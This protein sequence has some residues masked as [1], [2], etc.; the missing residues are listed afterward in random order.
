M[1]APSKSAYGPRHRRLRWPTP[2]TWS[3]SLPAWNRAATIASCA[4]SRW[5][6]RYAEDDP[7]TLKRLGLIVDVETTGLDPD[8]DRIIELACL[9]FHFSSEGVLYDVLPGY[10]GFEDPGQP[11]HEEVVRLTGIT[12][13]QLRGQKLD[14]QLVTTLA[15]PA[16]L[17]IAHNAGFD[18]CFLERRFPLFVDK[19]WACSM[20]QV[21]WAE[22]GLGS[23][24]LDYLLSRFGFFFDDHRAMADCRAV[25]H[26]L[27][28]KLPRSGRPILPLLLATA[29]HRTF[30]LWALEAPIECKDLLKERGYR[31]NTGSEA[32]RAPGIATW[33]GNS[34][35]RRS[36]SSP[37]RS[38]TAARVATSWSG[39][40]TATASAIGSDRR[41]N[42]AGL[43]GVRASIGRRVWSCRL[44]SAGVP[45]R[46]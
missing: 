1:H 11:L 40:T 2:P 39:S 19:P 10:A 42:T 9:P 13:D 26:L 25:L 24:K 29:R 34:L 3:R 21:P 22:E 23:A 15:T 33:T 44:A 43:Y 27:S 45:C 4:A 37:R 16:N 30:R 18:R 36:C 14:D 20:G 32:G 31:W 7:A 38:T 28:L 35:W 17:I 46:P 12:D 5:S 41:P 8:S 6:T